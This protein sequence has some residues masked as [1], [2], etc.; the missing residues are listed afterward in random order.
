MDKLITHGYTTKG[1]A[2]HCLIHPELPVDPQGEVGPPEPLPIYQQTAAGNNESASLTVGRSDIM[3]MLESWG[4]SLC[5]PP[6]L[7][8]QQL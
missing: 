5:P 2:Y 8:A 3:M 6:E 1:Y 7:Q 4:T